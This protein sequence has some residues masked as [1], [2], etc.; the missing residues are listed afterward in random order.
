MTD[1][2]LNALADKLDDDLLKLFGTPIVTGEQLQK[3]LGFKSLDAL[4]QAIS[5]K[6]MP[7]SVFELANRRGKYALTKDIAKYLAAQ[8]RLGKE[9]NK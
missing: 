2:E 3:A 7:V 6:T 1:E 4:R 8:A 5:R 9:V